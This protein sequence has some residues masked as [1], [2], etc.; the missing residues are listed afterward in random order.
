MQGIPSDFPGFNGI[1]PELPPELQAELDAIV[2][3][4]T[5]NLNRL[6]ILVNEH[7]L[8]CFELLGGM[9]GVEV[10]LGVHNPAAPHYGSI[11][12]RGMKDALMRA[13]G[14]KPGKHKHPTPMVVT[15]PVPHVPRETTPAPDLLAGVEQIL[16]NTFP[17]VQDSE[18]L[19]MIYSPFKI[20]AH[21]IGKLMEAAR[22][23][24][25]IEAAKLVEDTA[26]KLRS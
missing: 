8:G 21:E 14:L 22:R 1:P 7:G 16:R 11:D 17:T 25:R 13:T 2:A 9:H 24:D 3:N 5:P 12:L 6:A 10:S 19:G 18:I 4:V 23:R 26:R 20:A 15:A